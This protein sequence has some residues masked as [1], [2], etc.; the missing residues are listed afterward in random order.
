MSAELRALLAGRK[1]RAA[2]QEFE[3]NRLKRAPRGF[4]ED[5]PAIDLL[6]CRQWGVSATLPAEAATQPTLLKQIVRR[7]QLA[8]PI[9]HLLNTPLAGTR[10][11]KRP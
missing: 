4:S 8:A 3:G 10:S 9:V 7:F 2:M 11:A 6:L 5:S 1:L